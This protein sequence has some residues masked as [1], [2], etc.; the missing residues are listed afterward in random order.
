MKSVFLVVALSVSFG[1]FAQELPDQ[2]ITG[3]FKQGIPADAVLTYYENGVLKSLYY[4]Y[5]K[6]YRHNGKR[7]NY[8]LYIAYDRNGNYIMYADD[9]IG[10]KQK[11]EANGDMISY[12]TYNRKKSLLI[13]YVDY[14]PGN[15]KKTVI[16]NRNRYDYDENE[17]LRR[18]WVRNSIRYDKTI[19][20]MAASFYFEEYD[21]SGNIAR[22]GRF[23]TPL[24]EYDTL[25]HISTG[26][27]STLES[28]PVHDFKEIVYPQLNLKDV[29]KWDYANNKTQV[30]RLER[31]GD[32]WIEIRKESFPR[33]AGNN[34]NK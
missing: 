31:Q 14:F 2:R 16:T 18:H 34:L 19:G 6:K 3:L 28:V 32:G 27:P 15:I 10:Y 20:S 24:H 21:V 11:S 25:L 13:G 26:F 7:L 22:S 29:F 1:L 33:Q 8:G 17:R 12:M 23:Y 4:P 9:R 30:T 5:K